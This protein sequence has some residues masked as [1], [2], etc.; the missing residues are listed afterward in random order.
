MAETQTITLSDI[1]A[2]PNLM[3]A[4]VEPGDTYTIGEDGSIN[5]NRIFNKE[6]E[7]KELGIVITEQIIKN[8]PRLEERGIVPG[9]RYLPHNETFIKTGT[10][11]GWEQ[12]WYG[13]AETPTLIEN[14]SDILESWAPLGRFDLFTNDSI[15]DYTSPEEAYGKGFGEA[16]NETQRAMI[17]RAKERQLLDKY[18]R[19]FTPDPDSIA[20]TVGQVGGAMADP[21]T[22]IPFIGKAKAG[23]TLGQLALRFAGNMGIGGGLGT[24]YSVTDDLAAGED[25]D[26]DKALLSGAIA[27]GGTG[28]LLGAGK[29][30]SK[31]RDRSANKQIDAADQ[32][33]ARNIAAGGERQPALAAA[34]EEILSR[35]GMPIERAMERTGRKVKIPGSQQS[36]Q[37]IVDA[38]EDQTVSRFHSKGL[39]RLFGS[40]STRIGNISQPVLRR[41]RTFEFDTRVHTVKTLE[42]VEPFLKS[43]SQMKGAQKDSLAMHLSN[44]RFEEAKRMMTPHMKDEFDEVKTVLEKL[45]KQMKKDGIKVGHVDNYFPRKIQKNS[46]EKLLAHWGR[47]KAG[48]IQKRLREEVAAKGYK[49]IIEI[50]K[51][52]RDELANQVV[53][54]YGE[55]I[56]ET[57]KKAR[58]VEDV[59]SDI[60]KFYS[61]PEEALQMY[62]R[63]S[64]NS[65]ARA[66]FFNKGSKKEKWSGAYDE[67]S[68]GNTLL[69][70]LKD[71][72]ANEQDEIIG[73]IQSRMKGGEQVPG[74]PVGTLRDLG[75]MG[76]IANPISAITQ[77]GDMG[78]SGV[79]HGF[80]NTI[81]SM[82]G[83]KNFKMIDIGLDDVGQE[84]A[85]VRRTSN[86][87]RKLFKIS[88]FRAIDK[89]GKETSMDAAFRKNI[90][91]VK[92]VAGEKA[93]RK[94]WGKFYQDDIDEL[95][96]DLKAV[97]KGKETTNL[98]KYHAFNELSDMQPISML[99]MP[100]GYI[101]NPNGRILYALKTFTLKQIDVARRGV[102]GEWKA[103][104]KK[105]AIANAGLLAGYLSA[106]NMGTQTIK[107]ILLGRDPGLDNI[108]DKA[109]WSLLG[110]YGFHRY[111]AEKYLKDGKL[112]E[113]AANTVAP[114]APMIDAI[115][116][117]AAESVKDDPNAKRYLRSVPLVGPM[118]YNWFGGGAEKYNERM[119]KERRK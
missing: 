26:V 76:T 45:H 112:T 8:N 46:Y 51:H 3:K 93:F 67:A 5:V 88:G 92:T 2:N 52:R 29:G 50:P 111:G 18:G 11:S 96:G 38:A 13:A 25:I 106:A 97:G 59:T 80:R 48:R 118:L 42:K 65:I 81:A 56:K 62:V 1:R 40:L 27:A 77:L 58:V 72:S 23:A 116:G 30:V 35:G 85:D 69:R 110:V 17:R 82:F 95:I 6:N 60:L 7:P 15:I 105:R 87:L 21:T 98:L 73:L 37:K 43:L 78:V 10:D 32:I 74:T 68:I 14:V 70:E 28:A 84:F 90:N 117:V 71:I 119:D 61:S 54:G 24:A 100:Q 20:R 39:D 22:L 49:N 91:L 4:G 94:K 89:L 102:V 113:W 104:N 75:Y 66:K 63:N 33:I 41:L 86:W 99:E 57:A 107:D 101:D 114:A 31:L 12:F 19:F 64:V 115:T 83:T 109:L 16:D 108:P 53:R 44:G 103:G 34:Q 9:D 55:S 79:L 36:A 47:D